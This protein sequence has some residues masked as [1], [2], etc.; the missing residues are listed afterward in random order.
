MWRRVGFAV[1]VF[2]LAVLAQAP[3][4]TQPEVERLDDIVRQL[5][6]LK[7]KAAA[8]DAQIE[9]LL[10]A[11]SEQRGALQQ[12]PQVYNAL[13]HVE[14]MTETASAPD[15]AAPKARCGALTGNGTR[16]TRPAKA[17]SRYCSQHQMA[18][19]K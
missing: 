3:K 9:V 18:H 7:A 8:M 6:E 13:Q 14:S 17:G 15:A 4:S 5:T 1:L 10:R 11:L 2:V 16:C 19:A 12:K